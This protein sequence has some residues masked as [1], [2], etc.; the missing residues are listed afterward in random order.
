MESF[1]HQETGCDFREDKVCIY[2]YGAP[3]AGP[4]PYEV[5]E[6]I[7]MT[8]FGLGTDDPYGATR[9]RFSLRMRELK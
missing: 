4:P 1:I 2:N 9:W 3:S 6:V 7:P 5:Y 8:V